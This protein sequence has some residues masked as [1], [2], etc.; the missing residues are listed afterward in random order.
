MNAISK[1]EINSNGPKTS[2]PKTMKDSF[3]SKERVAEARAMLEAAGVQYILSCWVDLL[4]SPKTK[5]VPLSKL[6]D[7]CFG[8]GPQF[9][10]HSVSMVPE[11]GASDADQIPIPDLDS[12]VVCP[13]DNTLAWVF[14]DLWWEDKPY[15]VCPRQILKRQIEEAAKAGYAMYAGVEP[16]F[17]V[18]RYVDG[19][20]VK[21]IDD[22][23][24]PG[25]GLRPQRQA[26]GYD[27]EFSIDSMPYLSDVMAIIDKLGWR[28]HDA[29]A[30]G[31]YSQFEL[32]F[33]YTDALQMADRLTFLR[34]LLKEVAK[35]HGMFVSFM[36]KTS[37]GDWRS[38]AHIN[39]SMQA[40]D[41]PD[42]N[43]FEGENGEWSE[44]AFN[45]IAGLKQHGRAITA[46]A[47]PTVNSYKGL[48]ARVAGFEGGTVT[49]APTHIAYGRNNRSAMLRL[50]QSRFAIENRATDMTM[51]TYL[52]LAMT[53]A[54]AMEGINNKLDPGPMCNKN[55]YDMTEAEMKADGIHRLPRTLLEAIEYFDEDP[56]AKEVLG[57]VLHNSFSQYKHV[58]WDRFHQSVTEWEVHEY[59]RFF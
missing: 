2:F 58:E 53:L 11:L 50:P 29:V 43:V 39:I 46:I 27:S 30:E 20:P 44:L 52:S 22:D 54:S 25:K 18:M 33:H 9:A 57:P 42:V 13:W 1:L 12:L 48:T 24:T 3:P 17:M 10:V 38:G 41:K 4:G 28:M 47:C 34:V 40:I 26:F 49:W 55:L 36:P 56:L 5:P 32:D 31:A 45:A 15:A 6:E 16:E 59:L 14:A 7:L 35:K 37:T 19:K 8:K 23:P 21:A 51:N